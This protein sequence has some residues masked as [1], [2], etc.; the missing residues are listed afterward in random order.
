MVGRLQAAAAR[1]AGRSDHPWPHDYQLPA[2][3]GDH[4]G[5]QLVALPHPRY[6][7][8]PVHRDS[9]E[10]I[11]KEPFGKEKIPVG[12]TLQAE[13]VEVVSDYEDVPAGSH[14]RGGQ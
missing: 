9:R 13:V 10:G 1:S 3:P 5:A 2:A 11:A 7:L 6:L 8:Q 14:C 4:V 12:R